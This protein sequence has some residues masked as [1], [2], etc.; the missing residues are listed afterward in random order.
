ML[1]FNTA[2]V[3]ATSNAEFRQVAVGCY[4]SRNVLSIEIPG[5]G[6]REMR[7]KDALDDGAEVSVE[8]DS[9][10]RGSPTL[11][12][13]PLTRQILS[14]LNSYEIYG[15]EYLLDTLKTDDDV[16]RFFLDNFL[17]NYHRKVYLSRI[18]PEDQ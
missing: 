14:G 4:I 17:S 7:V 6:A 2:Y 9:Q 1:N 15:V 12:F 8:L 10:D 11:R 5:V 13:T 3:I 16:Q 18:S